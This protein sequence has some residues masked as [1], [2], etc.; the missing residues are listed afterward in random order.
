MSYLKKKRKKEEQLKDNNQSSNDNG[1]SVPE[2]LNGKHP[3]EVG[4][5]FKKYDLTNEVSLSRSERRKRLTPGKVEKIAR[6]AYPVG[7]IIFN[8]VYWSFFL[9]WEFSET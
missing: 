3:D 5:R 2:L 9:L 7:F 1:K 8:I 4:E 6:V